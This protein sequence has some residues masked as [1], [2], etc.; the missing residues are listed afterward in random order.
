MKDSKYYAWVDETTY[1]E[2]PPLDDLCKI[3]KYKFKRQNKI[4]ED[5]KKENQE[6]KEKAW[7]NKKLQEMEK[8]LKTMREEYLLGF[9]ISKEDYEKAQNWITQHE[10]EKH[11]ANHN[12]YPRGGCIGG[13]YTWEFIPTSIGTF[14]TVKCSCGDNFKFQEEY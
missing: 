1:T 8:E 6:L 10:K 5:L 14:G 3:L 4:I 12:G 11:Y 7:E 13:A 2:V 9:P